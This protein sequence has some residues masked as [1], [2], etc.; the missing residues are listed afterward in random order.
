MGAK[1]GGSNDGGSNDGGR[2]VGRAGGEKIRIAKRRKV[3]GDD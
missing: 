1:D 3:E 2:G